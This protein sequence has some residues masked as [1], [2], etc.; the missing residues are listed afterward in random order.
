M[1]KVKYVKYRKFE[2]QTL[3]ISTINCY[4]AVNSKIIKQGVNRKIVTYDSL[5]RNHK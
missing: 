3:N 2:T 1:S 4:D 5:Y